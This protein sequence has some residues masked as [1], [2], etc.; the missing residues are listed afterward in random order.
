MIIKIIKEKI[1]KDELKKLA[2]ENFGEMIKAAVDIEK[3]IIALGGELHADANSLLIEK[4]SNQENLWGINIYPN[5]PRDEWLEFSALI[6]IRPL[7]GNRSM[8]IQDPEIKEKIKKIV[9]KLI[10]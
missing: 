6:N 5:K 3:E 1:T 7:V 4:G 9:D 2:E 10:E 8:E